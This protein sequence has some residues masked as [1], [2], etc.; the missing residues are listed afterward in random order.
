MRAILWH[1]V[2]LGR[3]PETKLFFEGD[4]TDEQIQAD[5]KKLWEE[6]VSRPEY[7]IEAH[8]EMTQ[9]YNQRAIVEGDDW[10]LYISVK[11][12]EVIT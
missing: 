2:V 3:S 8:Q 10:I 12:M 1:K 7:D 6:E 9:I 11:E 5:V 4:K